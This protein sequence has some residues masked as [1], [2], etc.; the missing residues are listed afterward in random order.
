MPSLPVALPLAERIEALRQFA[1]AGPGYPLVLKPDIGQRGRGVA[2]ADE[3]EVERGEPL[4]AF[5]QGDHIEPPTANLGP[6]ARFRQRQA[7]KP[8]TGRVAK[9]LDTFADI[10][11]TIGSA[12]HVTR[13]M[14]VIRCPWFDSD[15]AN[16]SVGLKT[17]WADRKS[18]K[19][20]VTSL[21]L[22]GPRLSEA[23]LINAGRIL[24]SSP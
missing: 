4:V 24:E 19:Y 14:L 15:G 21:Q 23:G 12:L 20:P 10:K 9:R 7:P 3:G 11:Q 16:L 6:P 17:A 1:A 2:D 18:S 8:H 22:V 5:G 13:S